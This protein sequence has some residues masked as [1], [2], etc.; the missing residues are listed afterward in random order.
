MNKNQSTGMY[1]ILGIL[2]MVFVS[3]ILMA[4]PTT[5]TKELSYSTFLEKLSNKEFKSIE[6]SNDFLIAVPIEQPQVKEP[7]Q[8][9]QENELGLLFPTTEK[10]NPI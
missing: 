5:T 6:K 7:E 9:A 8:P 10:R 1:I 2:V 4:G 3:S